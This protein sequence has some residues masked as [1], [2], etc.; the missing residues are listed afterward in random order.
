[1]SARPALAETRTLIRFIAVGTTAAAV[2]WLVV[3]ALVESTPA[4]PLIA[5]IAGW[6]AAV[7]VS[8]AGHHHLTFAGHGATV[9][10]SALRFAL[11]SASGFTI[12][13]SAY[14]VM[15]RWAPEHYAVGLGAVL[16][17]VAIVTYRLSQTWAFAA[18]PR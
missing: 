17:G 5:N 14:A 2:H 1:M 10:G 16:V 3:V 4:L 8:F 13:E 7:G 6:M 12:N 15:L 11:L 18:R 9:G